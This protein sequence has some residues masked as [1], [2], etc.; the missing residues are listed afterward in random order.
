[1]ELLEI[2][3]KM[4]EAAQAV[5]TLPPS[6]WAGWVTYLLEALQEH[7]TKDDYRGMLLNVAG[8]IDGWLE[9]ERW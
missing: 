8:D 7:A 9:V 6:K 3:A 2:Q 4:E 1:M 5:A